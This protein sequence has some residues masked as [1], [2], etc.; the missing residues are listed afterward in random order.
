[1][2][3][4]NLFIIALVLCAVQ[5]VLAQPVRQLIDV[6]VVPSAPTWEAKTGE[7]VSFAISVIRDGIEL[8]GVDVSYE[9]GPEK[10]TPTKKESKK[11][12]GTFKVNA[13]TLHS[14]LIAYR[15]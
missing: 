5:T 1:M 4:L 9:F 2:Y 6:R 14:N 12:K 7:N 15:Q 11:Y 8:E 13:G 10:M 3:R